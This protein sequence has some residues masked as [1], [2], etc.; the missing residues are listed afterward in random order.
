ME[1]TEVFDMMNGLKLHGTKGAYDESLAAALMR[2]MHDAA[3]EIAAV[4]E[5]FTV[6]VVK[7]TVLIGAGDEVER[8]IAERAP[9]DR[10]AVVSNPEFLRE[11]AP[12]VDFK[13]PDRV[14]IGVVATARAKCQRIGARPHL[15]AQSDRAQVLE[16]ERKLMKRKRP[17]QSIKPRSGI[18]AASQ[19]WRRVTNVWTFWV[20]VIP[21]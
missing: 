1:R 17:V 13:R 3:R 20:S 18:G 8:I 11:G 9:R 4:V 19:C 14:V 12:I 10:F 7:S 5:D 15:T 21:V 6:V 2:F 16:T